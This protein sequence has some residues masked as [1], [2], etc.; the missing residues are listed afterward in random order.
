VRAGIAARYHRDG[1]VVIPAVLEPARV[2]ACVEHLRFLRDRHT[3]A[4]P[5]VTAP[6][7]RDPFL[8]EMASDLVLSAIASTLLEGEPVPFGCTY[9]VKEPR[10]G[11]PVLWHQD[12]YPWRSHLGIKE[13][14]TLW[15]ALD[16]AD[17]KTGGLR[18][19]PGSHAL[20]AQPLIL[21]PAEGNVFGWETAPHLVEPAL[22][23]NL[24]LAAG[25]VSA[26]HPNL[27]HGS[28]PNRSGHL[29]RA[30]AIRYRPA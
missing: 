20:A 15:V 21:C 4:G 14:V 10:H 11:P 17:E 13:A 5:I 28:W 7:A 16:R 18:V 3:P 25:D 12:G 29:R 6:L 23:Q 22:A 30:L 1:Y 27:I 8:A 9:F 2:N 24:T 19:I 26:H